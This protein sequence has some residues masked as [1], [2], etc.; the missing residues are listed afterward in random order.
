MRMISAELRQEDQD[1]QLELLKA[2][3]EG[4]GEITP[5]LTVGREGQNLAIGG[6]PGPEPEPV[7]E[8]PKPETQPKPKT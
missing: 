4:A 2:Q 3:A 5:A 7:I 1:R 8:K 6:L